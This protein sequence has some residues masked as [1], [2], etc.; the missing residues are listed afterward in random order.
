[1]FQDHPSALPLLP[2]ETVVFEWQYF[3]SPRET[4]RKF[5]DAGHPVV[6]CPS[7]LSYAATWAHLAQSE[8][9]VREHIAAAKD[10]DVLGVCVTTWEC[11][12]FGNYET[13]L[14]AITACGK[15]MEEVTASSEP[16]KTEAEYAAMRDAP[17]FLRSYLRNS[18]RYEEWA[19]L[20]GVELQNCGGMFAFGGI[21]SALKARFLLYSNPF[22]LWLR[23]CEDLCGTVG[24][25]ALEVLERAIS[26]APDPATR[27]VSE[28]AR[29]AIEFVRATDESHQAY[30]AGRPG[31]SVAALTSARAS[32]DDLARIAKATNLRIGG[33][34]ADIERC[35]T[36]KE[37][38][39]RVMRRITDYGDGALG[40]RPS[41]ETL[42]H[43]K[44]VP[45][46]QANWW[47]I[48]DWANE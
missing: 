22:L 28:F 41:F 46:D 34:L 12:L 30:A 27:G 21:R 19:R 7:I 25:K 17:Y 32:F 40:Y 1:M 8:L 16:G 35:R 33:S 23:N 31:A 37:H 36:A 13:L 48:N 39:E 5:I 2:S 24:D 14:P 10:M 26:V 29:I 43:P 44:F 9:N 20:M 6:F 15:M 47:L 11:A 38:V 4:A 18:E 45:H 42:T 3:G